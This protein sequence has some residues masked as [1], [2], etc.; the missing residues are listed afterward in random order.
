MAGP[1]CVGAI[2]LL[3]NAFPQFIG[4]VDLYENALR[5]T[6]D[7]IFPSINDR[8]YNCDN[9]EHFPNIYVGYG[10]INVWK[11]YLYL[12][13]L[14]S[15]DPEALPAALI[16]TFPSPAHGEFRI[17]AN[18]DVV[19]EDLTLYSFDGKLVLHMPNIHKDEE[20]IQGLFHS[21]IYI[22]QVKTN[23]GVVSGK[24]VNIAP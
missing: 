16:S 21:G 15:N 17:K 4:Q 9:F 20:L 24:I 12:N 5:I 22:Y 10:R 3:M 6:A 7:T 13:R 18:H 23:Q 11:A 2:A 14:V 8:T 19:I 1:H